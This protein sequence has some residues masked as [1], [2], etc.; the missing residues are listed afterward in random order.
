MRINVNTLLQGINRNRS[1]SYILKFN[2]DKKTLHQQSFKA[3]KELFAIF[4]APLLLVGQL[5]L[6]HYNNYPIGIVFKLHLQ[7]NFILML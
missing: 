7:I 5:F 3:L 1:L 6:L 2:P 4:R